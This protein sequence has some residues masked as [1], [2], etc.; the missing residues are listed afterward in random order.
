MRA[1]FPRRRLHDL[2][3][4]GLLATIV[5]AFPFTTVHNDETIFYPLG[6]RSA[7]LTLIVV[8]WP[9][10]LASALLALA[11]HWLSPAEKR[12][13][14]RADPA[15]LNVVAVSTSFSLLGV[16]LLLSAQ[17]LWVYVATQARVAWILALVVLGLA[18]LFVIT[19]NAIAVLVRVI[20]LRCQELAF[21]D[22]DGLERGNI[23]V[24]NGG[25]ETVLQ[26][27]PDSVSP[28]NVVAKIPGGDSE[29]VF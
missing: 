20:R 22:P 23:A 24:G 12:R 14:S 10:N 1:D 6:L 13:F 26:I 5:S 17:S 8:S 4:T 27:D 18:M 9:C 11:V 19:A 25:E 16:L 3:A 29:L 2:T 28:Q 15:A 21:F 7:F